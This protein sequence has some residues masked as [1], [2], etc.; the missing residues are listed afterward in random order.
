MIKRYILTEEPSEKLLT[1]E[2]RLAALE[3]GG[4]DNWDWYGEPIRDFV[5]S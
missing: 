1:A 4:V 5:D 3:S 2:L